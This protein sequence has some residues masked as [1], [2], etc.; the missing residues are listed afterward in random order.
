[1]KH[2]LEYEEHEIRGLLGDLEKIGQTK[3]VQAK[4]EVSFSGFR[5]SNGSVSSLEYDLI[6]TSP[7]WSTGTE[8]GDRR[9]VLDLIQRGEFGAKFPD[10][11]R[12]ESIDSVKKGS[13]R[14]IEKIEKD[15]LMERSR[16]FTSLTEFLEDLQAELEE[17]NKKYTRNKRDLVFLWVTIAP[18]GS[19]KLNLLHTFKFPKSKVTFEYYE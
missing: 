11:M 13:P 12:P 2:L 19:S 16:D 6:V 14:I 8:E 9:K 10:W 15:S 3:K 17:L 4:V 7:F 18:E 5:R 1:M